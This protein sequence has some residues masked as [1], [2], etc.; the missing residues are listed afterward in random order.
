MSIREE[1][2]EALVKK[3]AILFNRDP[4]TLGP[5][6]RFTE[7]LNATSVNFVQFSATLEDIYDMEVPFMEL[8]RKK[9]FQEVADYIAQQF[10]E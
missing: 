1:V 9:T 3:A 5:E 2:I 8:R 4:S 6:T 10:G 7:D